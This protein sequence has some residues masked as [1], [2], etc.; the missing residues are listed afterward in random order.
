MSRP[1]P[2]CARFAAV[3]LA[4]LLSAP[5]AA[6]SPLSFVKW[7]SIGPV[8]T[9]GRIDDIAVARVRG[10]AGRDVCRHGERR[11]VEEREQRRLV[12]APSST[13]STR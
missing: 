12:V 1:M 6:Q 5:C 10:E 13:A 4:A 7:R 8:N 2:R 11:T 9:S 3:A